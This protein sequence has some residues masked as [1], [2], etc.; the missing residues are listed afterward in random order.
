MAAGAM[1]LTISKRSSIS[2]SSWYVVYLWFLS[3]SPAEV[4]W[5]TWVQAIYEKLPEEAICTPELVSGR[6]KVTSK[7]GLKLTPDDRW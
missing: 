7:R 2:S 6:F 3:T 1:S 4:I 5:L